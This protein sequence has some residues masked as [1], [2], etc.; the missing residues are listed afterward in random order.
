MDVAEVFLEKDISGRP[1]SSEDKCELESEEDVNLNQALSS[2]A[3]QHNVGHRTVNDLLVILG[4][5]GH[6][7][8]PK[9]KRTLMGTIRD[10]NA[11]SNS[12]GQYVYLGVRKG[13]ELSFPKNGV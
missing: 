6:D 11:V 2:W 4:Q 5:V 13:I 10:I 12:G 3:F 7:E 1:G 8:L 9:D